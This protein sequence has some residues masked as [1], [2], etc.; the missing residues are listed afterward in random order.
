MFIVGI[1]SGTLGA[2]IL[3]RSVRSRYRQNALLRS[4]HVG[5][6]KIVSLDATG[7]EIE[8]E[9]QYLMTVE[10]QALGRAVTATSRIR[11]DALFRAKRLMEDGKPAVILYDPHNE[12]RILYTDSLLHVSPEYEL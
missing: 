3:F 4:G 9:K 10:F 12:M 2:W 8:G 5:S 6:A 1:L 7:L 11:G